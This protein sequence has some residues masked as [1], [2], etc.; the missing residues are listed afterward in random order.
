MSL[1]TSFW[2]L[3]VV[4]VQRWNTK[5]SRC[6]LSCLMERKEGESYF[7]SDACCLIYVL[8]WL[9]DLSFPSL[10]KIWKG[11]GLF[12]FD[13]A[14]SCRTRS[15]C[16][17]LLIAGASEIPVTSMVEWHGNFQYRRVSLTQPG[18][19]NLK[20]VVILDFSDEQNQVEK[21]WLA[22]YL[23]SALRKDPQLW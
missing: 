20:S 10:G 7:V 14:G 2:C 5:L 3:P 22:G 17:S 8:N 21:M 23:S 11:T 19:W 12:L 15:K 6:L 16:T 13:M 9:L 18:L 4:F 1:V